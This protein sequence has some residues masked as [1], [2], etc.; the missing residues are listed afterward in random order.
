M[1]QWQ[2]EGDFSKGIVRDAPRASIPQGGVYNAVDYMLDSPGI[3]YKRGGTVYASSAAN[4][5]TNFCDSLIYADGFNPGQLLAVA[6]NN[7]L[8]KITASTSTDMGALAGFS[9]FA[10][11]IQFHGGSKTYVVFP[12][13][14]QAQKYNGTTIST[15][16]STNAPVNAP[17]VA[18]YQSRLAVGGANPAQRIAFGPATLTVNGTDIDQAWDANAWADADYPVKG[19]ASLQNALLSFSTHQVER[20]TGIPPGTTVSNMDH[21]FV[22]GV[23]CTDARS[24]SIWQNY[25]IFCNSRSVFMTNGVGAK[26]ML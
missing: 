14:G 1:P 19:L 6:E 18:V 25:A 5:S 20:F 24:I 3:C 8:F 10:K 12:S 13:V 4:G 22:A 15:L 17:Y 11:P 9:Q 7:H 21:G 2:T 26:D 16:T 23:G